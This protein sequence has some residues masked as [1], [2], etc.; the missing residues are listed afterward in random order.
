LIK[1]MLLQKQRERPV[2]HGLCI[3]RAGSHEWNG[4]RDPSF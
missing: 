1:S 3:F 2:W 4:E